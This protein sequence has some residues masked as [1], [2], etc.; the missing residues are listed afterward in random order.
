MKT[1]IRFLLSVSK[2]VI[3]TLFMS[4][5]GL[6]TVQIVLRYLVGTTW[7]WVPDATRLMFVWLVFLGAAVL[8]AANGHMM[9][10]AFVI[11]LPDKARRAIAILIELLAMSLFAIMFFKG[12]EIAQKRM[13]IPFDT[14]DLPTGY[15]YA[16][17]SVSAVLFFI[18]SAD[19][20]ADNLRLMR[21]KENSN[22]E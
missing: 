4:I 1:I 7:L 9:V 19:R 13:R 8:H 10:D 12:I 16:A 22:V 6:F 11:R 5:F 3:T 21:K 2:I 18:V 14:W 15:A 17:I 20:L